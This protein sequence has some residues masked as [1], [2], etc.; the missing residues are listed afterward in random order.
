MAEETQQTIA[1]IAET[2]ED[3]AEVSETVDDSSDVAPVSA[4]A[5]ES[6]VE[7]PAAKRKPGR[8]A[9]S[10]NKGPAKPRAARVKKVVVTEAVEYAPPP[11]PEPRSLHCLQAE[12]QRRRLGAPLSTA[13]T[14]IIQAQALDAC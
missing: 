6:A 1:D 12:L 7:Q 10:L 2:A 5:P 3:I 8:P 13:T 9:G 11:S 14:I 4:D